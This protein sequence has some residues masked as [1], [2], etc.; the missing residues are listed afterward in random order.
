MSAAPDWARDP[1]LD[2]LEVYCV[3]GA[4]RDALLGLVPSEHDFVVVG[5]DPETLAARGFRAV[6]RDFP[7]FLHPET[8]AEF[9]LART[10]RKTAPGYG[11]FT[12]HTGS[13]VTLSD[14]LRRRDLTV[15]AIAQARDG[16]L[17]DPFGGRADLARKR[18]R[19]V[20]PAFV[21]DPLRVLRLARFATRFAEFT[22]D[23]ETLA[24]CRELVASGEVDHLVPERVWQELARALMHDRPSRFFEVLRTTGALARLLPELDALWGVPQ[25]AEYHPEIDTGVH[26]LLVIDEAAAMDTSLAVRFACL[27]HDLGKALTPAEQLPRH[28]GHE[29][30]GIRPVEQVS[31]RLKVPRAV[32]ELALLVCRHH[33]R[34]HRV[35]EMRA[36]TVVRFLGELDAFRR[37]QRFEEFV[38]ACAA[39]KR[40]R[41]GA[42]GRDYPAG[43]WLR[44]AFQAAATVD[45]A[46]L[47]ETPAA[48]AEFGRA[49]ARARAA[50]VAALEHE[51]VSGGSDAAR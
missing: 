1:R 5:A 12:F 35:R 22:I 38:Q 28:I 47:D 44:R 48:G 13:E 3:G 39:D 43:D 32:R 49:L 8:S 36:D 24:L 16:T 25:V 41:L 26:T 2:G 15:N 31:E 40:G 11:G 33:L 7:V 18:L 45:A 9:A 6:G 14:D 10:E 51:T 4:V 17:H 19:H 42:S 37:P 21:E 30:R 20:S 23:E 46:S 29:A 27:V 34:C 50:R